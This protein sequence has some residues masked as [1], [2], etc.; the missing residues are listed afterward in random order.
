MKMILHWNIKTQMKC[1]YLLLLQIFKKSL[2]FFKN[3]IAEVLIG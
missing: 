3:T 2:K 1:N